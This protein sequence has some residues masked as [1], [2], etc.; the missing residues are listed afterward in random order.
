MIYVKQEII[1]FPW[2]REF[3]F[4]SYL[5]G[6]APGRNED[7][8][9]EPFVGAAGKKL[10]RGIRKCRNKKEMKFTLQT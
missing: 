10:S 4:G 2:Q 8:K 1:L 6:E 7:K 9:G 3:L 5:C